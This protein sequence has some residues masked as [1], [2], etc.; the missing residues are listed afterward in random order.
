MAMQWAWDGGGL[1]CGQP[2]GEHQRN[3]WAQPEPCR[4]DRAP[5]GQVRR[6]MAGGMTCRG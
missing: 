1:L 2:V 6:Q 4:Q 3:E 5:A